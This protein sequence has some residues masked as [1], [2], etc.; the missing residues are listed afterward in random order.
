LSGSRLVSVLIPTRN[1]ADT[2]GELLDALSSQQAPFD[3]EVVAVDSGS[4]D[5]TLDILAG[6]PVRVHRIPP[7][8]FDH[9]ET[10]NLGV[11]LAAGDPIALL[12]QDALPAATDFLARL[13]EPFE[14]PRV[15]GVYGRQIPREDCDVVTRRHLEGW[16]TGRL[17]ASLAHLEGSGLE[18]LDPFERLELCTFDNVCSA[19]RRSVWEKVPFPRIAIGEDV[20]WGRAVIES[21]RAIAYQPAAAVHHSHRRSIAYEYERTRILH[22]VLYEQFRLATVPR[23]VDVARATRTNLRQDLPYVWRH[24]PTGAERALQLARAAALAFVSPL[25]Q[26]L[27]AREARRQIEP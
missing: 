16:L 24:A 5:G 23:A 4:V 26:H 17:E 18:E 1:G 12:T 20:A 11:R 6:Y 8:E 25:A 10:R 3:V 27:G 19:V 15:A 21:G 13:M 9:G 14:D 7:Q 2:L 22:R